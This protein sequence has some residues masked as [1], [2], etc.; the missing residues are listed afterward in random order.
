MQF[1][2]SVP[3]LEIMDFLVAIILL[4]II[5]KSTEAHVLN[6]TL[7]QIDGE[8]S[9]KFGELIDSDHT[10][11]WGTFDDDIPNSGWSYL[12]IKT[13]PTFNNETQV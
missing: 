10:V 6:A 2:Q 9:L 5:V 4:Q 8:F 7:Q 12:E 11:A 1:G 13:F 3:H